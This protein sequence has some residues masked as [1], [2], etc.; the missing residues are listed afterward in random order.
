M[1]G[2]FACW[3]RGGEVEVVGGRQRGGGKLV[4]NEA[5]ASRWLVG[6]RVCG[7]GEWRAWDMG[8]WGGEVERWKRGGEVE[9]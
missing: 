6:W 4:G 2:V 5:V 8:W 1:W 9:E 3:D 7:D